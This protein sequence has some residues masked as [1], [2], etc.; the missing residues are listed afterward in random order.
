MRVQRGD[1]VPRGPVA[2]H[3]L[4]QPVDRDGFA[5]VERER[6]EQRAAPIARHPHLAAI[7]FDDQPAE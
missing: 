5:R 6:R 7:D 3:V 4:D 1:S 2:P